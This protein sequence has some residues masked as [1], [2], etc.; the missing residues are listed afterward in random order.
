MEN[1]PMRA[2]HNDPVFKAA[3]LA[4][5]RKHEEA[6]AFVKGS[7][8]AS[9]PNRFQGCSI[10]CTLHSLNTL[11]GKY[12]PTPGRVDTHTR[13]PTELEIPIELAYHFDTLFEHL[14]DAESQTWTRRWV[15]AIPAGANLES[16]IPDLLQWMILDPTEG[17]IALA[18]PEHHEAY[19]V[20]AL[21]VALDWQEPGCVTDADWAEVEISLATCEVWA[22]AWAWVGAWAWAE[23][24]SRLSAVTLQ[25][26]R[27]A[28]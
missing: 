12:C 15:E 20:F 19:Q 14:P 26:L 9:L 11:N 2:F 5:I 1:Q 7:Y 16:V 13:F 27:E 24:Y 4:E 22:G 28:K 21:L 23:S 25:L 6:D 17:F 3:L 18:K 10:G 8:D